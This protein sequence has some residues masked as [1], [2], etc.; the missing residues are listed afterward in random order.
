MTQISEY[1]QTMMHQ[2][3]HQHSYWRG[4]FGV[5]QIIVIDEFTL[6]FPFRIG[7]KKVNVD[8]TFDRGADLYNIKAI[9]VNR[10]MR[11]TMKLDF[12]PDDW[13]KVTEECTILDVKGLYWNQLIPTFR[14]IASKVGN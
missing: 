14:D 2:L 3:S 5:K 8:L 9:D 13:D 10:F 6:R 12:N 11:K 1:Q 4:E 7:S